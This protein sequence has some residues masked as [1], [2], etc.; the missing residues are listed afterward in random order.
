[1]AHPGASAMARASDRV[2]ARIFAPRNTLG[3][4]QKGAGGMV[5]VHPHRLEVGQHVL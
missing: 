4:P 5:L 2:R 3:Q 1:M